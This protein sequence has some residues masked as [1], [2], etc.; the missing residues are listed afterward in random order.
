MVLE[1][2]AATAS[3][4]Q[5][6]DRCLT[7]LNCE[8]TCPSGVRYARL[9]EIGRKQVDRQVPRGVAQRLLR[10]ALLV[11]L[12]HR[13]RF[14]LFVRAG[15]LVRGLLP[16]H[17]ARPLPKSSRAAAWP[18]RSQTRRMLVFDGC[19]QP[20]LAPSINAAAARVLDHLGIKHQVIRPQ[21]MVTVGLNP[22]QLMLI[23]CEGTIGKKASFEPVRW[24]V[25]V[26]GY[27]IGASLTDTINLNSGTVAGA[28]QPHKPLQY[29]PLPFSPEGPR[30]P[31][32][33]LLTAEALSA[34]FVV[35]MLGFSSSSL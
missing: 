33:P 22:K 35:S 29:V 31:I 20:A 13:R 8:T 34:G 3:I 7:C 24:F 6:L 12:P 11:V 2:E 10:K 15:S 26:G 25:H 16:A 5:H 17:L 14:G 9:L 23:N 32:E 21:E 28:S 4:Q 19:A 1:G 27:I 30:V 18:Q